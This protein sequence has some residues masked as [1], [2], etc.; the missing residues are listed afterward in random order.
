MTGSKAK[1]NAIRV[2]YSIIIDIKVDLVNKGRGYEI[3]S[4]QYN[5]SK[6]APVAF[7]MTLFVTMTSI[8]LT[9]KNQDATG[10]T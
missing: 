3:I 9:C 7:L 4:Q 5:A 6:C 1:I 2:L 8:W 10:N